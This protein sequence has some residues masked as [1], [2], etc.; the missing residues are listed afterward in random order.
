MKHSNAA[1]SENSINEL[2]YCRER[3]MSMFNKPLRESE[4]VYLKWDN[5]NYYVQVPLS[6][7]DK[8]LQKIG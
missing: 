4:K 3:L 2:N 8:M 7:K 1:S 6:I 5:L